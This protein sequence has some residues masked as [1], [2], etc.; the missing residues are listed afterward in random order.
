[1]CCIV[2]HSLKNATDAADDVS[3]STRSVPGYTDVSP[4]VQYFANDRN[5]AA[6]VEANPSPNPL[7]QNKAADSP[8]MKLVLI[9]DRKGPLQHVV[10]VPVGID[11]KT[12]GLYRSGD[13]LVVAMDQA[14]RAGRFIVMDTEGNVKNEFLPFD[15]DYNT[16]KNARAMQPLAAVGDAG[17]FL[18]MQVVPYGNNLLLFPKMTSHAI[19][20][21]NE[22]GVVHSTQL[23]LPRGYTLSSFLSASPSS[24]KIKTFAKAETWKDVNGT[25]YG[26]L[27]DGP[28]FEFNPSDGSLIRRIDMPKDS[29]AR[30]VCEH[31]GDYTALTTDAKTGRLQMLKGYIPR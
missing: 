9:Y 1:M 2:L 20:E 24:W 23:Q 13:I 10:P 12:V 7:E 29:T 16:K 25:S 5:V 15:N 30:L 14:T 27:M 4:P 26:T 21:V 6:L 28:V 22:Q 11:I 31:N 18:S 8:Q 19:V 17:A 3:F